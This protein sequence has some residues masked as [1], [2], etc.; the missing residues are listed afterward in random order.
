MRSEFDFVALEQELGSDVLALA[1]TLSL[2]AHVDPALLRMA[3]REMHSSLG[4]ESEAVVFHSTLAEHRGTH[5]FAI[6]EGALP[7]LRQMLVQSARL[8]HARAVVERSHVNATT[9]TKLE[10]ELTYLLLAG[11]N[12]G[13]LT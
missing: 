5:G 10:E 4:V 8:S 1:T 7:A 3:R 6:A 13:L 9:L 12:P 2:A 11:R